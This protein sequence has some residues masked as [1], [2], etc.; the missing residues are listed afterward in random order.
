MRLLYTLTAYPPYLG[1]AQLHQHILAQQLQAQHS[2]QA[3]CHWQK[4]R[5]DWLLGTT[6]KAPSREYDYEIDGIPVHG[7]GVAAWE[8]IR[9]APFVAVYYP[10]WR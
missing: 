1:G 10:S 3:I 9:M 7:L 5:T 8:K 2:I 6:L 4:N